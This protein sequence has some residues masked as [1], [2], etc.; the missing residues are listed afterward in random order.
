MRLIGALLPFIV[1]L[2]FT[3]ASNTEKIR[4]DEKMRVPKKELNR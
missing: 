3:V 1:I 4:L 2:F